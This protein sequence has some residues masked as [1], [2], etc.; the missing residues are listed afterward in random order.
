MGMPY[1]EG[2]PVTATDIG[3]DESKANGAAAV[4]AATGVAVNEHAPVGSAITTVG[5]SKGSP[6]LVPV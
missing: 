1:S 3:R 5:S 6:T 2:E 4:L